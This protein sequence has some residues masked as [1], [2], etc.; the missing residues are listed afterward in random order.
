MSTYLAMEKEAM[1]FKKLG[2]LNVRC[3]LCPH[4]CFLRN[5]ERGKCNVRE[6]IDGNLISLVY[7]KPCSLG[8]DP[9][10]KKPLFHFMP[11][12]ECL[13]V[14]TVG[15]NLKCKFCQNWKISQAKPEK[16]SL[17][18]SPQDIV[19]EAI[20]NKVKI[21]AYTYTEPTIFYE[22]ML[23]I[24]KEAKKHKIK[25]VL[26]TNGFINKE[27]LKELCKYLD[28]ANIDLKSIKNEFYEGIC[29]AKLKPVLEAI[30]TMKEQG[31]WIE[32]TNLIIPA[33]NDSE[34][35]I[36]KIAEW[37]NKNIGNEVPL[38]FSAF[39]PSYNMINMLRT[40]DETIK[41]AR[42]IALSKGLKYVYTG[43]IYDFEGENTYCW[44]CK[45]LLI[46]RNKFYIEKNKIKN[47]KCFNCKEK[48]DGVWN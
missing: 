29:S 27:P 38:H 22:Y 16:A 40:S 8:I 39:Y 33:L 28:A 10:E 25:N 35:E 11:G 41:R 31:I 32:I 2:E 30:K 34:E 6:N 45:E 24:A 18:I 37:I 36:K 48:I 20:K 7:G 23:E 13:S 1:F 14:A 46:K 3:E 43:N 9:I 4:F 19:K 26:V 15:C 21:I 17:R 44:K 47:G 5:R 12:K 42:R